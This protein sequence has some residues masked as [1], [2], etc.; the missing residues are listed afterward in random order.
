[1]IY[2]NPVCKGFYPDPS[3]CQAGDTYYMVCS[4]FQYFPAIP[5]FE[6][7][8]LVNWRQ[9][10]HVLTRESQ[11]ALSHVEASGGVFAATIRYHEG[12]FYV[13]TTNNTTHQH[14]YVW[15]EDIHGPWSEPKVV[16]QD[17]IDPSLFFED[18][19]VYFIS[20]GTDDFG[21]SGI[22]QSLVDLETGEK[23]T[24]SRCVWQGTGGRFPEGP[25][26]Y[27]LGPWY[28]LLI[29]EGGTEFGH[30]IT[31][32]RS[33]SPWGP[34][35]SCPS[36]PI[37][38]NR[39]KA[40]YAIQGIGHGDLVRGPDGRDYLISLGFR[41]IDTWLAYHTLGREVFLT[42]VTPTADGW[43]R[44]GTDGTTDFCYE[45]AI[46]GV[47]QEKTQ[48]TFQNTPWD[49]EWAFLRHPARGNYDLR[50]DRALLRGTELTLS[51][52]GSPTFVALRQRD[53]FGTVE[54]RVSADGGEAGLTVYQWEQAH[55]DLALRR[56]EKGWEAIL[57]LC[58]GDI[59][60]I[61]TAAALPEG[62]ARLKISM[63]PTKYHFSVLTEAGEISLGSAQSRWLSTE[64][65]GG[66][67]GVMLGLY[68]QGKNQAEFTDFSCQYTPEKQ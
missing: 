40:P 29:S 63:E 41:Q 23:K 22:I 15:T 6:S 56:G 30:M 44:A 14:F 27:H 2:R 18:G 62:R 53:F 34:F 1:M 57:R 20:N 24:P 9:I 48:Y 21:V 47:Q 7:R 37:L 25:H 16:D 55:Y 8:D 17:G 68:A 3:V 28:Y 11:V 42:P 59:R 46:A 35:E 64:A 19:N 43:L 13:V 50:A 51:D 33:R 52:M 45:T 61:Q 66:F 32:A 65:A 31:L 54:C 49:V 36:N 58:M 38:T 67:T 5:L 60:H 4:S 26:L 10:G 12:R 39:N